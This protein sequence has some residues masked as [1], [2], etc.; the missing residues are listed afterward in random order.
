MP[1]HRID[2]PNERPPTSA[3]SSSV[4]TCARET[5]PRDPA[6]DSRHVFC[7]RLLQSHAMFES[8]AC[9]AV[10]MHV[11]FPTS[12]G[13]RAAC[14][15]CNAPGCAAVSQGLLE[16]F[17]TAHTDQMCKL[18]ARLP[19]TA[20]DAA[21]PMK[22]TLLSDAWERQEGN[23]SGE[24]AAAEQRKSRLAGISLRMS[25]SARGLLSFKKPTSAA[26]RPACLRTA[27]TY[28][29]PLASASRVTSP[30]STPFLF[31]NPVSAFVGCPSL[32][33]AACKPHHSGS[34]SPLSLY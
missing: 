27:H 29:V 17:P 11:W 12:L 13:G 7:P 24:A 14:A 5:L 4:N 8:S 34:I 2:F 28:S 26:G 18:Q 10:L 30:T 19:S 22:T 20:S 16:S 15:H 9:S 1:F 25:S 33:Y 31:A 23:I 6:Q 21:N 32:P 3:P